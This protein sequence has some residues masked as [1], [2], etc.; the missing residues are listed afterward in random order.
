MP[1]RYL[2]INGNP[3]DRVGL[4]LDIKALEVKTDFYLWGEAN[5]ITGLS[6]IRSTAHLPGLYSAS[7]ASVRDTYSSSSFCRIISLYIPPNPGAAQQFQVE[8]LHGLGRRPLDILNLG[9]VGIFVSQ[10][11]YPLWNESTITVSYSADA[12]GDANRAWF[13]VT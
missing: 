11:Q 12:N 2:G 9:S 10:S 13:L 6:R 7:N 8:V 1:Q 3:R 5:A 4:D